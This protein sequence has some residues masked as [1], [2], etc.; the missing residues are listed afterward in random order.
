MVNNINNEDNK[1]NESLFF[2][3]DLSAE[4]ATLLTIDY[5]LYSDD[6]FVFNVFNISEPNVPLNAVI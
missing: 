6:D 5:S 4:P 1:I 3:I 2:F